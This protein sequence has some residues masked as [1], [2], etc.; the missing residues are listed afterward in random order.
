MQSAEKASFND[1]TAV[2]ALYRSLIGTEGCAWNEFYPSED[3]VRQDIA[4]GGLY[5][6]W[7]DEGEIVAACALGPDPELDEVEGWDSRATNP[8]GLMRMAVRKDCQHQGLAGCLLTQVERKAARQGMDSIRLLVAQTN[9]PAIALYERA[10]YRRT[11][12]A[13][14]YGLDWFCYEK[15]LKE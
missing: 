3:D 13:H 12:T 10:L 9:P 15:L 1:L 11:G 4:Q 5:L 14:M 6:L 7:T 8:M 2:L